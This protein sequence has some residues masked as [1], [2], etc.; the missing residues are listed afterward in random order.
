MFTVRWPA[1]LTRYGG[2]R[3]ASYEL[4]VHSGDPQKTRPLYRSYHKSAHW[5]QKEAREE[6]SVSTV[7]YDADIPRGAAVRELTFALTAVSSLGARSETLT[8]KAIVGGT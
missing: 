8:A 6:M 3:A 7:V 4:T 1:A 2:S 5:H